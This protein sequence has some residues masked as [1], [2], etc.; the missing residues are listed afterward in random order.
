ML[1]YPGVLTVG[2]PV[3]PF[4]RFHI[5]KQGE[6]RDS[7][8]LLHDGIVKLY[9]DNPYSQKIIVV[10]WVKPGEYFGEEFALGQP[11][12]FSALAVRNHT[13]GQDMEMAKKDAAALL[14][15]RMLRVIDI[16]MMKGMAHSFRL[17]FI[18]NLLNMPF[19]DIQKNELLEMCGGTS[20]KMREY[21][22]DY[23]KAGLYEQHG[24]K[25]V[26]PNPELLVEELEHIV[27]NIKKYYGDVSSRFF[28]K[29][30]IAPKGG[31]RP[32]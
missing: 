11:A 21:A 32:W 22:A 29:T 13:W 27:G 17:Q 1:E 30:H 3:M 19:P 5:Y 18:Y 6:T 7:A 25:I 26:V 20:L 10:D 23:R 15:R 9:V 2:V 28:G 12:N 8:I 4:K 14:G 24:K 31:K 16:S